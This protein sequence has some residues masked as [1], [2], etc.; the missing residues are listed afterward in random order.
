ML[1]PGMRQVAGRD[2]TLDRVKIYGNLSGI[3][4]DRA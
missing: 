3:F 4:G 1:L 2:F